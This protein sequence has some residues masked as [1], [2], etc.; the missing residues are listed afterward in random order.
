MRA[1]LDVLAE[2]AREAG[3]SLDE[4][5]VWFTCFWFVEEEPG[6]A[7]EQARWAAIAFALHFARWG[8]EGRFVPDEHRDAVVELGKAYDLVTHG[9]VPPEQQAAYAQLA[10][11]LGVVGVPAPPVRLRR[12]RRTRSRASSGPRSTRARATSTGRSTPSCPSTATGSRSGRTS[13]CPA[14]RQ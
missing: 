9:A 2:G 5:D 7:V 10:D 8:V 13:S 6:A 1:S 14:S 11:E 3:R 12:A 4:I